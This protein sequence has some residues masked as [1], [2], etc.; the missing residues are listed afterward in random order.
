V[1][2]YSEPE[3]EDASWAGARLIGINNR[4][5]RS[6]ETSTDNAINLGG[7]L[8]DNMVAVAASGIQNREDILQARESG[9]FNFLIGES[10]VRSKHP[11]RLIKTLLGRDSD[12]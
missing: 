3:L 1:E 7:M 2:I 8:D 4:N 12:A 9:I 10:L 11:D 5:L 6:F